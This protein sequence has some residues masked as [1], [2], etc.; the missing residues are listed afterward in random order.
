ML[1]NVQHNNH[2]F[3]GFYGN[4]QEMKSLFEKNIKLQSSFE[5]LMTT[6]RG[7][8][9]STQDL[10]NEEKHKTHPNAFMLI[11]SNLTIISTIRLIYK[12]KNTGYINMVH[13][14]H[15]FRGKGWCQKTIL[16]LI[17]KTILEKYE[18]HVDKT[19]LAAIRC[20][21]KCGFISQPY[22]SKEFLMIL[23]K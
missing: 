22:S 6:H 16:L 18:L 5:K 9:F 23:E 21:E 3:K 20:Y 8:Y 7:H 14:N 11:F 17:K 13:V 2:K 4:L 12:S 19:N 1:F 10:D 15:A